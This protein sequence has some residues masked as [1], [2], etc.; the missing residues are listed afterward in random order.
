[1]IGSLS[2]HLVICLD[3]TGYETS[4]ERDKIYVAISDAQAEEPRQLRVVDE[5]G[6]ASL[7]PAEIFEDA[8]EHDSSIDAEW[9]KEAEDRLAAYLSGELGAVDAEQVFMLLTAEERSTLD[10]A[11][12]AYESGRDA[13]RPAEEVIAEIK[14]K[15]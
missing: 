3:N 13:G 12:D 14:K 10:R 15:L 4:L 2:A 11:L 5:S 6:E 7:Y 9:L 1:M 8:H